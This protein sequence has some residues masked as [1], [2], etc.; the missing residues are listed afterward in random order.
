[1]SLFRE[2]REPEMEQ[3]CSNDHLGPGVVE[4][5]EFSLERPTCCRIPGPRPHRTTT[6][7][8]HQPAEVDTGLLLDDVGQEAPE[9]LDLEAEWVGSAHATA[10]RLRS[11]PIRNV[12]WTSP[13]PTPPVS[14]RTFVS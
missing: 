2:I 5:S 3:E 7:T 6:R 11:A 4:T 12:R 14:D 8:R 9:S 10:R 1:M 13:Q